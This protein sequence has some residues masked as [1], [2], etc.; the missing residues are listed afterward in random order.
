MTPPTGPLHDQVQA[1]GTVLDSLGALTSV[2]SEDDGT[3]LRGKGC[4]LS[5]TTGKQPEVCRAVEELLAVLTNAT[6][7]RHCSDGERPNCCFY[8]AEKPSN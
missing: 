4:P 2:E 8:L 1:I 6:V 3:W 7:T 5:M